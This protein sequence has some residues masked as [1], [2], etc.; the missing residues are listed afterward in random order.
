MSTKLNIFPNDLSKQNYIAFDFYSPDLG[1]NIVT[2]LT[3][4]VDAG[5]QFAT[6]KGN[7]KVSLEKA[8]SSSK[9]VGNKVA[10]A[11]SKRV[12]A[13]ANGK[14]S[15]DLDSAAIDANAK[16]YKDSIFM[17]LTNGIAESISNEYLQGQGVVSNLMS[18]AMDMGGDFSVS[19]ALS[20]MAKFTGSRALLT[21]PDKV[22]EYKGTGLRSLSLAWI[23][24]PQSKEETKTILNIIRLFKL[25]SAPELQLANALLLA[26]YFCKVTLTNELL[27][28]VLRYE[29]MMIQTVNIT[30]GSG[31][32]ME[33]FE[34]GMPKEINLT[35][36]LVERRMKTMEDWQ[37]KS[38]I[39]EREG[40]PLK[41]PT[42]G[43]YDAKTGLDVDGFSRSDNA[44]FNEDS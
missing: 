28:E 19:N 35:L 30:Y 10:N 11:F 2:A 22:Q 37:D 26:P 6:G 36:E 18:K 43:G 27:N 32:A 25:Y 3:S 15:A 7:P 41:P 5:V 24:S 1:K 9:A 44:E 16:T 21:N 8:G 38:N 42:F 14:A 39:K 20:G 13:S 29:E 4:V 40:D 12:N 31:G 17:P 34:D 33:I 23:I